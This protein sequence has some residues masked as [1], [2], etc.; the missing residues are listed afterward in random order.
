MGQS[1]HPFLYQINTR[2]TL[3]ELSR[4]FRRTARLKDIPNSVVDQIARRGFDWVWMLGIWQTGPVGQEI[5]RGLTDLRASLQEELPDLT[6]DDIQSSPF[7]IQRY[8]PHEA[9]G[10]FHSLSRLRD[11]LQQRD[12]KLMLDFVPNHTAPDHLWSHIHP[13]YYIQGNEEDLA[14]DPHG[15]RKQETYY[16]PKIFACGKDPYFP[17][18]T[19]TLQLNYRHAGLR[20][21]MIQTLLGI[22]NLC[23]GVRCDMAM[24]ILP[25]VI[26]R[27]WGDRSH[28]ADGSSPVDA[29]FWPEAIGRVRELYP[30]FALMAEVYWDLEWE[31]QQ[32]GFDYTYDKRLYDRLREQNPESV[33]Q[34]LVA[35][36]N[37]QTKLVRFLENHDEPRAAK[38][39]DWPQHQATAVLS[40]S[41]PGMRFIYEG[42][43]EGRTMHVAMQ[44]GRRWDEKPNAEIQD[45]YK[46]LM[47]SLKRPVVRNGHWRQLDCNPASTEGDH[48]F[49]A[50]LWEL[51]G[52]PAVLT[53]VNYSAE[54]GTV[55]VSL[56]IENWRGQQIPLNDLLG[57]TRLE[58]SGDEL[59]QEG[60]TLE[61]PA[62]GYHIFHCGEE[63]Q[64]E[65]TSEETTEEEPV[66]STS[67]EESSE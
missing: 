49:L 8:V 32:Q 39:F 31:L 62:W 63:P 59:V 29:P 15:F 67:P 47:Q 3:R 23:D 14:R 52:Q 38:T 1:Q 48:P 28:P 20:E 7:A 46:R 65:P 55:H 58:K 35:D 61:L 60:L 13:E 12:L 21:A 43:F 10:G 40:Y 42:Q 54:S 11:R 34:H 22:A 37:F 44:L 53:I 64:P 57:P 2:I 50:F 16:G 19:D 56:P 27:T 30:D 18:W 24:L 5:A 4:K 25:D 41:L 9:F 66:S 26:H 33:R 51:E 6:E 17:A 45:F 36:L